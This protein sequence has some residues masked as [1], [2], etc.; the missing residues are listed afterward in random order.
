[1]GN[2]FKK[3]KVESKTY[4]A[5][6]AGELRQTQLITTFG[7]GSIVD[8]L[9]D[10]VI[11]AGVDD[12]EIPAPTQRIYNDNLAAITGAKYFISPK[13]QNN[14]SL[15]KSQDI[16]SYKF[17]EKLYC[18]NCKCI[19][20]AKE[21]EFANLKDK[22]KCN[23]LNKNGNPCNSNLVPSRFVVCCDNGHLEDFPYYW[24]VHRGEPCSSGKENPRLKMYNRD[25]RSDFESLFLECIECGKRRTFTGAFKDNA[26]AQYP[27]SNNHPHLDNYKITGEDVCDRMLKTRLRNSSSIYFPV[28]Q[29]ALS[30]PPWSQK[31]VK[32][33]RSNWSLL[34]DMTEENA[35]DYIKKELAQSSTIETLTAAYHT[36]LKE[37]ELGQDYTPSPAD[38][39][40]SEYDVLC[41]GTV[42]GGEE[43]KAR[44]VDF[45]EVF[46]PFFTKVVAV[47]KLTVVQAL[48]GFTREAPFDGESILFDERIVKLSS[49]EK[50]W[51]PAV[52]LYGEGIFIEF[53]KESID[54]WENSRYELMRELLEK[55][56]KPITK[57]SAQYVL[58]HTFS[59]IL[60][61]QL[62]EVCGYNAA[63]I[64]EKI[65][66]TFSTGEEMHGILIYLST[67]DCEGSLGGLISI[68]E[69]KDLFEEIIKVALKKALW[70][71]ADPLCSNSVGQGSGA[72]NY[73]AC[74]DCTLLPETSCETNNT[75][76]D[77]IAIVGLSDNHKLGFMGEFA[78]SL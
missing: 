20:D 17:P 47:T 5:T 12:W 7:S 48:A 25:N 33:I 55:A 10:T 51:L 11:I 31:A 9:D 1:M 35:L 15:N 22:N 76:L 73:A 72:L 75:L 37:R 43:Y 44:E 39:F 30:I 3:N 70:C 78:H 63:A 13:I 60:I 53:N 69:N 68:V 66:S 14:D 41:R 36:I 19:I 18:P 27:C 59:H 40:Y 32:F 38:V 61:R 45:A 24:W 34:E 21:L 52:K 56:N 49:E 42:D 26:L 4:K 16:A 29:S 62:S 2:P 74:H 57:F 28:V 54:N 23:Q 50:E 46:N 67:S 71:S 8:F 65:Y 64:G 58:M 6:I 77:R